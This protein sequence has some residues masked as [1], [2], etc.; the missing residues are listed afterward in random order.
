M[1]LKPMS[2]Y[3]HHPLLGPLRLEHTEKGILDSAYRPDGQLLCAELVSRYEESLLSLEELEDPLELYFNEQFQELSL[4]PD[5]LDL[6]MG[7][8]SKS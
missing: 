4:S 7:R 1:I 3:V 5:H 2:T 6:A 8:H